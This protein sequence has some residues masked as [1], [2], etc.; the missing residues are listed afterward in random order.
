M[1]KYALILC[2]PLVVL[3]LLFCF[4]TALN[5]AVICRA[6]RQDI[7][8]CNDD[9]SLSK[10]YSAIVVLGAGIKADGTP[11]HMLEDRLKGALKLYNDGVSD[12]IIVSG[13]NS[14]ESYDEVSAM[15]KYLITN[16]V[17]ENA[18]IRDDRGF[19]TYETMYNCVI[20]GG[21]KSIIA[22][23]QE[24]HLYRAVYIGVSMGADVDGYAT[25]YRDYSGQIFREIR[26]YFARVKDFFAVCF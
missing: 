5:V 23:T 2:A 8:S 25:D 12:K 14:G 21:Y 1:R 6:E 26:E 7:Y 19:S 11:S 20:E 22:V 24:Y 15:A 16:G 4:L 18:I 17:P 10:S 9:V 13:D 3:G